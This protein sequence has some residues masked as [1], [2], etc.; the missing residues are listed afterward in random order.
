MGLRFRPGARIGGRAG[1]ARICGVETARVDNR[2]RSDNSVQRIQNKVQH[3]A[4]V[5]A[6]ICN[7][8]AGVDE[9]RRS[10]TLGLRSTVS[11]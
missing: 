4:N 3:R 10:L 6:L 8:H 7:K 11:R 1:Q 5:W 9:C 2:T